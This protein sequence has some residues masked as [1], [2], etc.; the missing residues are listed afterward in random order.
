MSPTR[1]ALL[2]GALPVVLG[3]AGCSDPRPPEARNERDGTSTGSLEDPAVSKP[4]NPHGDH[5]F[6]DSDGGP[7]SGRELVTE[8]SDA[9][10]L[11]FASGV[12]ESDVRSARRFLEATDFAEETVYVTQRSVE[13]C[14]R[15]RVHAVSWE[16]GRVDFEYCRELRP[17]DV[18]CTADERDALAL[19]F[20]LPANSDWDLSGSGSSGRSPC[21]S[22]G[23]DYERIDGNATAED[24]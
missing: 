12:P 17:P 8:Q 7:W 9:D 21:R 2:G 13:S 4:R 6:V 18:R 10:R 20:R 24:T 5:V 3:L 22:S 1:R 14:E 19:L 23:T 16:P 11:T 15:Y